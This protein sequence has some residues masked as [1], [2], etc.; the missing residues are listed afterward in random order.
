MLYFLINVHTNRVDAVV[1][2]HLLCYDP[3]YVDLEWVNRNDF[4]AMSPDR[5]QKIA[6][7]AERNTGKKYLVSISAAEKDI[8]EAPVVGD[9]VSYAFNGDSYP[10]GTITKIA[11][12]YRWIETSEGKRFYRRKQTA[13]FLMGKT[14]YMVHGHINQRNPEF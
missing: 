12:N 3:E 14:W 11:V 1:D 2:R 9:P 13:A 8:V 7:E 6:D 4:R 10:C 5:L